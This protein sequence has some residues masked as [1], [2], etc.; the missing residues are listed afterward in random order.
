MPPRSGRPNNYVP[1]EADPLGEV[2][3][4]NV[5]LED[6]PESQSKVMAW[7]PKGKFPVDL[8]VSIKSAPTP[9]DES[10]QGTEQES[11]GPSLNPDLEYALDDPIGWG[12]GGLQNGANA[13]TDFL[14]KRSESGRMGWT[15]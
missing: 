1:P 7:P 3:Y 4:E 11:T 6:F 15:D 13:A 14:W 9:D 5:P 8:P 10:T 2:H 12:F